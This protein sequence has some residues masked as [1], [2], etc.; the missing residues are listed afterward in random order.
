VSDEQKLP[1]APHPN[2]SIVE[3]DLTYASGSIPG[4]QKVLGVGWNPVSD[5]LEFDLRG[6]TNSL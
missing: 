3:E 2:C 1:T 5:V 6:I 4:N